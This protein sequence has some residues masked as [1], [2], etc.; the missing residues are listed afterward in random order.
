MAYLN[1]T[2]TDP[3]N[4]P[5][6]INWSKQSG[7]GAVTFAD[8]KVA[9]TTATF[10]M[11]GDYVLAL[12]A[13]DG[14]H[15][16]VSDTVSVKVTPAPVVNHPPTLASIGDKTMA[17]G[18]HL[19]FTVQATDPDKDPITYSASGTPKSAV[20]ETSTGKFTFDPDYNQSGDYTV[21]FS[22][23]D[24]KGGSDSET[25]KVTV[26]NTNRVPVAK[27][28]APQ[29][30]KVGE[31]VTLDG[32]GSADPD[33][34]T[35]TYEWKQLSGPKASLSGATTATPAFTP[36]QAATYVFQLVVR[37]GESPSQPV[38]VTIIAKS[39]G[40]GSQTGNHTNDNGFPGGTMGLAAVI[41]VAIA[42]VFIVIMLLLLKGRKKQRGYGQAYGQQA[43]WPQPQDQGQQW[44]QGWNGQE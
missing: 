14:K 20:F 43:Y 13:N 18:D 9:K 15:S 29:E 32:S 44:D 16:A 12:E 7:P 27:A 4:D 23:S 26:T 10:S 39:S 35:L 19:S 21:T 41:A 36:Q 37:D 3:E 31:K 30:V 42:V 1:G 28:T 8:P 24:G 25:I 11:E 2:A 17:E 38:Q 22:A 34:D 6:T 40:G 5:L 33:G